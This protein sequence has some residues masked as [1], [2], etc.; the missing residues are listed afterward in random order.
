MISEII[1][2]NNNLKKKS[3][4][5]GYKIILSLIVIIITFVT[6]YIIRSRYINIIIDKN[7]NEN[8]NKLLYSVLGS[9]FYYL[10]IIIGVII[11]LTNLGIDLSTIL[12]I[13][14]SVGLAI[15]LAIQ[16]TVT[17]IVSG[18]VI[19]FFGYFDIGDFI[20]TGDKKGKVSNFN[21]LNTTIQ[22]GTGI[23]ITISNTS[24]VSTAFTNYTINKDIYQK[25]FLTIS[26]NNKINFNTLSDNIIKGIKENCTFVTDKNNISIGIDNIEE[27]GIKIFI[28]FPIKS[29]DYLPS[30][31]IAKKI[32]LKILSEQ[33]ITLLD[34]DYNS[35]FKK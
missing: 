30:G 20:S 17:Q 7:S 26:S 24:I 11:A 27:M 25:I 23:N 12:I 21:L 6:A 9:L 14:S 33:N 15:A 10:I 18:F 22:D 13:L 29:K 5:M 34:Y 35:S 31:I 16:S 4:E 28:K 1:T 32:A 8:R 19:L 2:I 3:K